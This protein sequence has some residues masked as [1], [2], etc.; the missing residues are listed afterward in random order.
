MLTFGNDLI[1]SYWVTD[2]ERIVGQLK[3]TGKEA[4]AGHVLLHLEGAARKEL[5]G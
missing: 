3:L 5:R 2:T 1:V 4:A